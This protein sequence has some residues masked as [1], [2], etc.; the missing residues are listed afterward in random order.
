MPPTDATGT[1]LCAS[2]AM[3][4]GAVGRAGVF[5]RACCTCCN[6]RR[7]YPETVRCERTQI[8]MSGSQEHPWNQGAKMKWL[9]IRSWW[10]KSR[11]NPNNQHSQFD[12]DNKASDAIQISSL[13]CRVACIPTAYLCLRRFC[14]LR[15]CLSAAH[16]A[17][18]LR[19]LL[20]LCKGQLDCRG[21]YNPWQWLCDAT[22]TTSPNSSVLVA[23]DRLFGDGAVAVAVVLIAAAF[24]RSTTA[25]VTRTA[26]VRSVTAMREPDAESLLVDS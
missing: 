7:K 17:E 25:T 26:R 16:Q 22:S 8:K 19:F 4:V 12:L 3:G 18:R 9:T 20:L 21:R 10:Q 2:S 5:A 13:G 6:I 15:T 14:I 24:T 11:P 1:M 23:A